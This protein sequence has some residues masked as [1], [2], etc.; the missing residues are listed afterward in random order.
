MKNIISVEQIKAA[1][2]LL[3][4]DQTKLALAAGLG[5]ATVRRIEAVPGPADNSNKSVQKM[6][7]ALETA[8]IQFIPPSQKGGAGVRLTR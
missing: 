5:I 2:H 6:Q 8:G 3:G 4:W 7:S 1:R